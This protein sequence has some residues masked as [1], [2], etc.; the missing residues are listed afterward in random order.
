MAPTQDN[1]TYVNFGARKRVQG[2][3]EVLKVENVDRTGVSLPSAATRLTRMLEEHAEPG[4]L[5]R[6][7]D[8]AHAGN[9]VGLDVRNGAVHGRVAGSQNEP[10]AVLLQLPYRSTDE[11]GQVAELLARTPNA[12]RDAR[13]GMVRPDVLDILIGEEYSDLRFSCTCPDP[14]V[15]CKHV[16]AVVDRLVAR[17]DADPTVVFSLRGLNLSTLEQL[18]MAK[19]QEAAQ[20][21]LSP[22]SGLGDEE[23]ARLFWEGREL[24]DLPEPKI[25]PALDDSDRELLRKA[26]RSITHSNI[27][28]LRVISDIEDLYDHLIR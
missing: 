12:V 1:V 7:R 23:R 19:A 21:A 13:T 18:L 22:Q 8:Y 24:P 15:L 26:M 20:D 25:A 6:G 4:R 17:M 14:Q 5:K 28:L 10:F 11:L 16:V 3:E 9:V 27:E 2:P